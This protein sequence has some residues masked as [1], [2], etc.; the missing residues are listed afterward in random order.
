MTSSIKGRGT[1]SNPPGRFDKLT[2]TFEYDGWY[3]EEA[4]DKLETTVMPEPARSIISR[5][6][7]PDIGFS[8]SINPYRGCEHACIYCL[9]GETPVLMAD[10]STRPISNI[11]QGDVI[12]GTRREGHYL[13][14]TKTPVL[15]HWSVIKP[16]FRLLLADG[17]ELIAGADHRFL[18][19]RGWKFVTGSMSGKD[20]RPYL[21]CNNKLMGTGRFA[22]GPEKG[23]EYQ[24][25]YLCGMIRGD[26]MIG[27]YHYERPAGSRGGRDQHQF[28]LALCD[29]EALERTRAYLRHLLV[30]TCEFQFAAANANRKSMRGIRTH[31]RADVEQIRQIVSWP[32]QPTREWHAGFLAGFFDAEGSYSHGSLRF[33][34]TDPE[35]IVW[36]ARSLKLFGFNIV[37]TRQDRTTGKAIHEVR[38]VG[39]LVEHLRFF[40][41]TDPAISRKRDIEGRA[42]KSHAKLNVVSI[43]PL[44]KAMRLYDIST[45]TED[46]VANGVVS[47]NCYARPSHAYVGLSPG[48]DFET[49]IFY[50]ADAAK[51][52]E[53]ELAAPKYRCSPIM[54]GANTDPYQ[55]LEKKL[56]VTRSILEVLLRCRHPVNITTKSALVARD[57]DLLGALAR[58]G[59][60]RVMF[61][62]PTLE[63]DMKRILEPRAAAAAAKLRAMR[64]LAEAGVSV[65]V[66]VAPIIPVLTEHEIESVLQAARAAGASLAGYTMLRLPWE[67][68]DLFREWLAEHFPDR[69]AH[70][71]SQVRAMRG[72]RDNDPDFGT[73]MHATGPV[74]QLIRQRFQLACRRLGFPDER[75]NNLPTNLF[76]PP[77]RTHPQ[78]ALDFPL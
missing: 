62:I 30:Q 60:A 49:K 32:N 6:D 23:M 65:G 44:G 43:E 13:R 73:R 61:S 2:Q 17:T 51:L 71:M 54:L 48:L 9:A 15:A 7:S 75:N 21:T 76:R 18:T 77:R 70:V 24:L 20:Q 37:V 35:M 42:V 10:G 52:L 41:S 27:S 12:Y 63:P 16:A 78:L 28:R 46:F 72:E 50:K 53:A 56:R 66:L 4:P 11:R 40:H 67:V 5:N 19:E 58:D 3:E 26:G 69:A 68:K 1:L 39:G 14:Y 59:L 64:V 74:A 55:P 34:N 31:A 47:H 25:G 57:V 38:I 45:G 22:H 8:Q 33:S 29:I 36:L